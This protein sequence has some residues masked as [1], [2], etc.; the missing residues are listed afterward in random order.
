MATKKSPKKSANER[1]VLMRLPLHV[2]Y[3]PNYTLKIEVEN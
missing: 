3:Q 1:K 2:K